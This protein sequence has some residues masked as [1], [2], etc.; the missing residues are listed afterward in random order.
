MMGLT[1]VCNLAQTWFTGSIHAQ[2]AAVSANGEVTVC[3]KWAVTAVGFV[4]I[5]LACPVLGISF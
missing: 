3:I 5:I 1:C 4:Q 2:L